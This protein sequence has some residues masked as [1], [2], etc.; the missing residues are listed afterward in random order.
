MPCT[1]SNDASIL[2]KTWNNMREFFYLLRFFFS[3]RKKSAFKR[4][5]V[6]KAHT[7]FLILLLWWIHFTIAF[8][9]VDFC[10]VRSPRTKERADSSAFFLLLL[11]LL[12]RFY[13]TL[14][15]SDVVV[16]SSFFSLMSCR[17]GATIV[18]YWFRHAPLRGRMG[19]PWKLGNNILS[20][21][22]HRISKFL[23]ALLL[24]Y[25]TGNEI[26]YVPG[27]IEGEEN[28]KEAFYCL[29]L[30]LQTFLIS[31]VRVADFWNERH[32]LHVEIFGFFV[33][34]GSIRNN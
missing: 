21:Y 6:P 7:F 4:L 20:R 16:F 32:L 5:F 1:L 10:A 14:F 24:L 17:H 9:F 13:L 2:S 27:C 12:F 25:A 11:V 8:A 23:G 26:L 34:L 30:K 22:N 19:W 18:R 3:R 28:P 33:I 31:R 15:S 29:L